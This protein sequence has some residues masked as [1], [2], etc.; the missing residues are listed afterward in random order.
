MLC[1]EPPCYIQYIH[2]TVRGLMAQA[3]NYDSSIIREPWNRFQF[4]Q[5][6]PRKTVVKI[7]D[8]SQNLMWHIGG[9]LFTLLQCSGD[10]RHSLPTDEPV[11]K[12]HT[13]SKQPTKLINFPSFF[14]RKTCQ[15]FL[16]RNKHLLYSRLEF[17][18]KVLSKIIKNPW[19]R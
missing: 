1:D 5:F 2:G 3:Y 18:R 19:N 17:C 16:E 8:R 11:W 14:R 15:V 12:K 13:T 10:L 7:L 4:S 6:F 9:T